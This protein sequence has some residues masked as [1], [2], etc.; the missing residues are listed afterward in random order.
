MLGDKLDELIAREIAEISRLLEQEG[1]Y[2]DENYTI[3]NVPC[4]LEDGNGRP[5]NDAVNC[6]A[7][8]CGTHVREFADKLG[9]LVVSRLKNVSRLKQS[10][11]INRVLMDLR[12]KDPAEISGLREIMQYSTETG[13]GMF[14]NWV[15]YVKSYSTRAAQHTLNEEGMFHVMKVYHVFEH[16]ASLKKSV[17]LNF[18]LDDGKVY[19]MDAILSGEG[20]L[21]DTMT[22]LYRMVA[23]PDHGPI[24][25]H[26]IF[27]VYRE[28]KRVVQTNITIEN[29][30]QLG[31]V[32]NRDE[33]EVARA[34]QAI[35]R[36]ERLI[37]TCIENNVTGPV[38]SVVIYGQVVTPN[39]LQV[40][41]TGTYTLCLS[42]AKVK[43][44]KRRLR[45]SMYNTSFKL[46]GDVI[47]TVLLIIAAAVLG[48]AR[49]YMPSSFLFFLAFGAGVY[50]SIC[51]SLSH[52]YGLVSDAARNVRE[53][54]YPLLHTIGL[55]SH[56]AAEELI[57]MRQ[58]QRIQMQDLL[59]QIDSNMVDPQTQFVIVEGNDRQGYQVEDSLNTGDF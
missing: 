38:T 17:R 15:W 19:V 11:T 23:D 50:S 40:N 21:A 49:H 8:F 20:S 42:R 45:M 34:E 13:D 1:S 47:V 57:R 14:A 36:F 4:R 6:T 2:V 39:I 44:W 54:L 53:F 37:V 26:A 46:T 58:I 33:N 3:H 28:V 52:G 32:P 5:G 16:A 9:A 43:Q 35:A 22:A 10:G 12:T 30:D 7:T 56:T 48:T 18:R 24:S 41:D 31:I 27:H 29:L 51:G 25:P 59:M 55:D